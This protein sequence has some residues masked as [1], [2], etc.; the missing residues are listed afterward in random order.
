MSEQ[1][2]TYI[3]NLNDDEKNIKVYEND[4]AYMLGDN[5]SNDNSNPNE[6]EVINENDLKDNNKIK[7]NDNKN[8]NPIKEKITPENIQDDTIK[9]QKQV[10]LNL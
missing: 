4:E 9:N 6:D 10:L 8:L 1:K 2:N 7:K 3:N 5:N